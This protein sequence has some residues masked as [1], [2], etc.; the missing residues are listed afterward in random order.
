[1]YIHLCKMHAHTSYLTKL[2]I[3]VHFNIIGGD[4]LLSLK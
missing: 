2:Q 1:M 4:E 3:Y